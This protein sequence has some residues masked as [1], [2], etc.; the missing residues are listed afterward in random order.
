LGGV[1]IQKV[2]IFC[3]FPDLHKIVQPPHGEEVTDEF[4]PG[5]PGEYGFLCQMGMLR[6]KLIVEQAT[7]TKELSHLPYKY[8]FRHCHTYR[9]RRVNNLPDSHITGQADEH[10]SFLLTQPLILVQPTYHI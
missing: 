5:Q 9:D 2:L 8:S 4:K 10:V 6:G 3:P 7:Q 1:N